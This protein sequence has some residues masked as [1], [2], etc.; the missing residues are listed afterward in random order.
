MLMAGGG[1]PALG[2]PHDGLVLS[3]NLLVRQQSL[4]GLVSG[5]RFQIV[6]HTASE[7]ADLDTLS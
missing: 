6:A 7:K 2:H 1:H 5:E 3:L 4:G